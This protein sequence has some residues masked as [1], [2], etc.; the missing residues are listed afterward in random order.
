MHARLAH[1]FVFLHAA[2][3]NQPR[4]FVAHVTQSL[5]VNHC[6]VAGIVRK[7]ANAGVRRGE[8]L[9][10]LDEG[11]GFVFADGVFAPLFSIADK[12]DEL[13][14]M[15]A[16]PARDRVQREGRREGPEQ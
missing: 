15:P 9:E 5:L 16:V 3:A 7:Q 11:Q 2:V 10:A 14:G 4:Q 1:Q 12:Q 8:T 13:Q 6:G